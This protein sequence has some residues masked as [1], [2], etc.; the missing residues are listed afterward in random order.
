MTYIQIFRRCHTGTLNSLFNASKITI[1]GRSRF[2]T[3]FTSFYDFLLN[4]KAGL[5]IDENCGSENLKIANITFI[6]GALFFRRWVTATEL[7]EYFCK[8]VK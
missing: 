6:T 7:P 3:C 5:I 4:C 2:R 8:V 1:I